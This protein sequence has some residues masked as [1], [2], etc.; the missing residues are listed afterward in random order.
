MEFLDNVRIAIRDTKNPGGGITYTTLFNTK[1]WRLEE[2][3]VK[4]GKIVAE[5]RVPDL[6]EDLEEMS[7]EEETVP[8]PEAIAAPRRRRTKASKDEQ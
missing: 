1:W 5:V 4:P 7:A 3:K 8:A 2:P 6:K